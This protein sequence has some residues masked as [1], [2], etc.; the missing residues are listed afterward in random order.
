MPA[1]DLGIYLSNAQLE[2][3]EQL[4][5][6]VARKASLTDT[7]F[8]CR[9]F[10][11][12]AI[13]YLLLTGAAAE[14]QLNL[15]KSGRAYLHFLRYAKDDRK[16]TS[17]AVPF[18]DAIAS[19]DLQCAKAIALASRMT[20]N[21]EEEYEEDFLYVAFLMGHF[22]LGH[23]KGQSRAILD[24]YVKLSQAQPDLRADMCIAFIEKDSMKFEASLEQFL[25][26]RQAR[27]QRLLLTG[28]I[29]PEEMATEARI[30]VE[31][32]A[33]IRLAEMG[34]FSLQPEYLLV[35]SICRTKPAITYGDND[36]Q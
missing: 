27:Y 21:A 23:D 13:G 7:L 28:A 8:V 2:V 5:A 4:P 31:G 33:L 11:M 6:V 35:P 16:C 12:V 36:W 26:E 15:H 9:R 1:S 18:F 24:P 30:S 19:G 25:S 29:P 34:G 3:E 32:L 17:K 20:W 14:F 10:R 22:F